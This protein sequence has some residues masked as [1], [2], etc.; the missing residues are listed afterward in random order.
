MGQDAARGF[1]QSSGGRGGGWR[2]SGCERGVASLR[3]A[4]CWEHRSRGLK[5]P[6]LFMLPLGLSLRC[7]RQ[8]ADRHNETRE[9]KGETDAAGTPSGVLAFLGPPFPGVVV[10]PLL[11]PALM[12]GIPPGWG[13]AGGAVSIKSSFTRLAKRMVHIGRR[14]E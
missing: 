6:G 7:R 5:P 9:G 4:G 14:A 8:R 13:I 12:A 2:G 3:D 10:A 11:D 1:R